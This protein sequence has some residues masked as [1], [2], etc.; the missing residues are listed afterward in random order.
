MKFNV[1]KCLTPVLHN[2]CKRRIDFFS[3]HEFALNYTPTRIL[4][5]GKEVGNK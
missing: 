3:E 4:K 1:R 5:D 2:F